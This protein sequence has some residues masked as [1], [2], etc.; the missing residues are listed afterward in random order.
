MV[1]LLGLVLLFFLPESGRL[2][3][4]KAFGEQKTEKLKNL[5]QLRKLELEVAALKTANP[6]AL[7]SAVDA[8]IQE[9]QRQSVDDRRAGNLLIWSERVRFALAGAFSGAAGTVLVWGE[10]S[11]V[12]IWTDGAQRDFVRLQVD[13]NNFAKISK[14]AAANSINWQYKAGGVLEQHANGGYN[15]TDW[16]QVGMTW[17][18]NAGMTGEVRYYYGG[19]QVG[20]TAVG[21]G[22]WAGALNNVT[23]LIGASAIPAAN[24]FSGCLG[25][26]A[27]F[28][29]ALTQPAIADLA[30][31]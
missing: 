25:H 20:A 31:I 15:S 13:G 14:A 3:I 16:F 29:R 10:V 22:V 26:C 12:G 19:A 5:L 6:E 23:T 9:M 28:D 30:T 4:H 17:D 1:A 11:G 18:V 24:V 27:L 7:N 2:L 8:E 21:L